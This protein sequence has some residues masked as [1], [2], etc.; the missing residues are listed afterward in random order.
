VKIHSIFKQTIIN[1]DKFSIPEFGSVITNY[2]SA[3]ID[4]KSGIVHPPTKDIKFDVSQSQDDLILITELVKS[5]F[6]LEEANTEVLNFVNSI[7][8]SLAKKEKYQIEDLGYF[9]QN[10]KSVIE[11]VA[12]C[13]QSLLAENIGLSSIETETKSITVIKEQKQPINVQKEKVVETKEV[14]ETTVVKET[15]VIQKEKVAVVKQPKEKKVR[16]KEKTKKVLRLMLFVIPILAIIVLLGI[17]HKPIIEKAKNIFS[18]KSEIVKKDD[19]NKVIDKD[20]SGI[21]NKVD[22]TNE[23]GNDEEY[24]KVL[25]AKLKNTAEVNLGKDFQKFYIIVGSYSKQEN[26]IKYQNEL[27]SNGYSAIIIEKNGY[28]RVAISGYDKADAL[29]S[30]FSTFKS[31]FGKDIWVLI[32]R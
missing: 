27:K 20:T 13:K 12:T 26:A 29:I 6:T 31:K 16:D 9:V 3:E 19:N 21:N 11:F 7:K 10:D 30:D 28:I 23:L 18:K 5:G 25:D 17:F 4:L 14:K 24:R 15:K 22:I 8:D 1:Y 32:N 2:K